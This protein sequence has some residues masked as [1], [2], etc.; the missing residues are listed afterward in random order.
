MKRVF[1]DKPTVTKP[2][3]KFPHFRRLKT[4]GDRVYKIPPLNHIIIIITSIRTILIS[5]SK[6]KLCFQSSYKVRRACRQTGR[7]LKMSLF[8]PVLVLTC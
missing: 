7:A 4:V 6:L 3:T 1:P 8:F 2:T 5:Y